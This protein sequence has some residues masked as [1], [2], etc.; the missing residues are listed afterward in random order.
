M[1]RSLTAALVAAA[2][3]LGGMAAAIGQEQTPKAFKG[4]AGDTYY[5]VDFV[6]GVEYW[7]PVYEMFKQAGQQLGVETV[8][9][10]TPEYDVNKQVAVFDQVLAKNP[11]GIFLAPMNPDPFIEPINRAHEM[12]VPVVTFASDSPNSKRVSYI[13]SDNVREGEWAADAIA[14]AMGGKGEFAVLENP[15]QDNHDK[16]IAAFLKRME[17]K[18]PDM[19]LAGRAASN[20]DPTKAYNALLTLAQA[21]PNLGAVFMPEANSALGAAQAA[22]EL[23]GKIK[24]MCADVNGK[25]LDMIKAGEVFGSI[26]PNQ[27][28]QG[29]MGMLMLFLA[30]TPDMIDPMNADKAEGRNPM[31]IPY[32]DNGLAVVTKDNADFFYW[33]AYLKRRGTK[34][35]EE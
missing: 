9:T 34:G 24:V 33:D 26:N 6:S 32:V 35:V 17:T 10:G 2:L 4:E 5:F 3:G 20:Q 14:E 12:G 28:M 30:A 7:F 18:W 11:K 27:G 13:T 21:N 22:K 31:A 25:I 16:R 8:Y 15:G 23:G 19:K 1:K 29:Y